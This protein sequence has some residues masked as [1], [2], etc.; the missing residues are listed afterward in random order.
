MRFLTCRRLFVQGVDLLTV[1]E[2]SAFIFAYNNHIFIRSYARDWAGFP[3]SSALCAR[4]TSRGRSASGKH[5]SAHP[6]RPEGSVVGLRHCFRLTLRS[7]GHYLRGSHH[8]TGLL[9]AHRE[10]LVFKFTWGPPLFQSSVHPSFLPTLYWSP[11]HH[12]HQE[13]FHCYSGPCIVPTAMAL[14]AKFGI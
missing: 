7:L 6:P 13:S 10:V 8:I 14:D 11:P 3:G 1:V 9:L 5:F 4:L 12:N 2:T